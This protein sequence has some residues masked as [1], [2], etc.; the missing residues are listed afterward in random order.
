MVD[1][2]NLEVKDG[3]ISG[4]VWSPAKWGY[5]REEHWEPFKAKVDGSYHSHM[6]SDDWGDMNIVKATWNVVIKYHDKGKNT[7]KEYSV[8]WG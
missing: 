8:R 6:E 7:P 3:W 1:F 2:R 5:S 4:E